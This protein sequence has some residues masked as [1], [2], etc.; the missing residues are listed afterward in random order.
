MLFEEFDKSDLTVGTNTT[1]LRRAY[2]SAKRGELL[3]I[4]G[5]SGCDKTTLLNVGCPSRHSAHI[6]VQR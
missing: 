1:I 2:R 4:M 5:P 3:A 6:R